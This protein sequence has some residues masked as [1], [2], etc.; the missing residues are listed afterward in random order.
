MMVNAANPTISTASHSFLKAADGA[1]GWEGQVW[2]RK[3]TVEST[4]LDELIERHGKP[5]FIKIDVEGFE[6]EALAGLTQPV[7]ALS[8]EFTTIQRD[9]AQACI[10]R[11][12]SLGLTRFNAAIGE[13][14]QLG[15]WRKPAEIESWLDALPHEANSGDIYATQ[16]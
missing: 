13:S 14:Q 3:I 6:E 2:D 11:C 8:F 15:A 16:G 7:K 9:V 5:A 4:T 12:V 10:A 1:V